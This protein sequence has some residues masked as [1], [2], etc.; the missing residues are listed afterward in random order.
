[1]SKKSDFLSLP[2]LRCISNFNKNKEFQKRNR[3][4]KARNNKKICI[5]EIEQCFVKKKFILSCSFF[6]WCLLKKWRETL[7]L[8]LLRLFREVDDNDG[9]KAYA[10][11]SQRFSILFFLL[12]H[13]FRFCFFWGGFLCAK[14]EASSSKRDNFKNKK[15]I[16]WMKKR[17]S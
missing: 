12:A 8:K 14:N 7:T 4:W 5:Y 10:W 11:T 1:M 13:C 2:F 15:K 6:I 17:R 9:K 3:I 16:E